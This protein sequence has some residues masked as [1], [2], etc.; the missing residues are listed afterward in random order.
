MERLFRAVIG[1][2]LV[3]IV[4]LAGFILGARA[5]EDGGSL[6]LFSGSS[7]TQV[8]EDAFEKIKEESADP[9]TDEALTR[10]AI[11]GM[12][13]VVKK[14]DNYASF[15][16]QQDYEAFRDYSAG[17]FSGIGVN[18]NTDAERLV[19]L[20]VIPETPAEE[21][22]LKRGDVLVEVDGDPISEMTNEEAVG[23][24]KGPPGTQVN[25]TVLRDRRRLDFEITRA[26]ISFPNAD[27]R[28]TGDDV[29][30][31]QLFGFAKGAGDDLR[32]EVI[33]LRNRGAEGY[34]LDLRDNGGGLL[35]E[36]IEV[37][38]VFIEEG[39]IVTYKERGQVEQVFD[40]TGDAFQDVPLV[41]LVNAGT[42]SASEIVAGAF[43]DTD[44]AQLV[45]TMTF[46]KGSVQ[47]ILALPDRS[48]VKL[49]TG[50]Y[51]SPDG[52]TI[53]G[54]GLKPDVEIDV[55]RR[56]QKEAVALARGMIGSS[57]R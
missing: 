52:R 29:G 14:K 37:A 6:D 1:V 33:D 5:A 8:I 48:A 31:I 35:S 51:Y 24:I 36:A 26:E 3:V 7:S 9:P 41:V 39:E 20:S 54:V 21:V 4:R 40:A 32:E 10:G 28:L 11:D 53:E 30:F 12:L 25:I 2:L 13:E 42:A 23:R 45:G 34:V 19:I 46:G 49:T 57:S 44:R 55:R 15:Y 43:Q 18:L 38:S 27:G 17:S 47:E 56:Q 22:G 16:D 50:K